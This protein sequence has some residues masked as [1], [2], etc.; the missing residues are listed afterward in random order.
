M[1]KPVH[2]DRNAVVTVQGGGLYGLTL[3]GQMAATLERSKVLALA[4]T[5]AGAIIAALV[6]AGW[7][8]IELRNRLC[9]QAKH[10]YLHS[11]PGHF[12]PDVEPFD[13]RSWSS[14]SREISSALGRVVNC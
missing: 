12:E 2:F 7:S 5:S 9:C 3:L 13:L 6:W 8:P 10:R 1:S 11:L 14:L 4:G